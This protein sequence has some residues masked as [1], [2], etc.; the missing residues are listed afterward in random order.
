MILEVAIKYDFAGF[1]AVD[2]FRQCAKVSRLSS[3]SDSG[4]M[5]NGS[6]VK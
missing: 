4:Q 3:N 5:H 1:L 2:L 6:P